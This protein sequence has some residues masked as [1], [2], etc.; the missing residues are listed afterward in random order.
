MLTGAWSLIPP[1]CAWPTSSRTTPWETPSIAASCSGWP[2][3]S[4]YPAPSCA[5]RCSIY[6]TPA[7]DGAGRCPRPCLDR[8]TAA[9]RQLAA[10]KVYKDIALDLGVATSTVR[11]H[12]HSVYG[13]L[14]VADRAQA[15]L[16]AQEM[17]WI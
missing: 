13:K 8:E 10:G 16:R 12:L 9:L 15:V 7:A 2:P 1:S 4:A 17:G 6:R 14:E 3:S 11:T 5:T